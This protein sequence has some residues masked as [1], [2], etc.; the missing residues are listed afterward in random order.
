MADRNLLSALLQTVRTLRKQF[1]MRRGRGFCPR[2]RKL[3]TL[4]ENPN[5]GVAQCFRCWYLPEEP[6]PW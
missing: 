4:Y 5:S 6:K 2:C 1:S 3:G